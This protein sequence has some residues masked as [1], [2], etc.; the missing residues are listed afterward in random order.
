MHYIVKSSN[1]SVMCDNIEIAIYKHL[2]NVEEYVHT[3]EGKYSYNLQVTSANSD[4]SVVI[5]TTEDGFTRGEI[6]Y[7]YKKIMSGI[8]EAVFNG[9]KVIMVNINETVDEHAVEVKYT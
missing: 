4:T 2:V 8:E 3:R 1:G 5:L 6:Q 9:G 7:V